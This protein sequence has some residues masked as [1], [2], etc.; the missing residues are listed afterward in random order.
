MKQRKKK[1]K[2][3]D[4]RGSH[5]SGEMEETTARRPKH[6]DVRTAI[7][8]LVALKQEVRDE[9]ER[10]KTFVGT[11]KELAKEISE[12]KQRIV[13][14]VPEKQ[15]YRIGTFPSKF[16]TKTF[17]D[18]VKSI[19]G[20]ES[21]LDEELVALLQGWL[22]GAETD[23]EEI[24]V[25][26]FEN[27]VA[28]N[29]PSTFSVSLMPIYESISREKVVQAV[30][31]VRD[32]IDSCG[33]NESR[34]ALCVAK[35]FERIREIQKKSVPVV[36]FGKHAENEGEATNTRKRKKRTT[37]FLISID[38]DDG[39]SASVMT[40]EGELPFEDIEKSVRKE[41]I[42]L[43]VLQWIMATIERRVKALF[44][45][46]VKEEEAHASLIEQFVA[47]KASEEGIDL[48]GGGSGAEEP[49]NF[50]VTEHIP[51]SSG[52][53]EGIEFDAKIV[54][55]PFAA[56]PIVP[57]TKKSVRPNVA[58][59]KKTCE[60]TGLRVFRETPR[61]RRADALVDSIWSE[62]ESYVPT[63]TKRGS[64]ELSG[65]GGGS[66]SSKRG[67]V[68]VEFRKKSHNSSSP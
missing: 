33:D 23:S 49:T 59:L 7:V 5:F 17:E 27:T 57:K 64:E 46:I 2:I 26:T 14:A 65:G 19:C 13:D 42:T 35:L 12:L 47:D 10:G 48:G 8:N 62:L 50:V 9:R 44:G 20:P 60:E 40:E 1:K 3:S 22:L 54:F 38:G 67:R 56:E 36:R 6:D 37:A 28:S 15:K 34:F 11:R 52:V 55:K 61:D 43:W 25:E 4:S 24:E 18:K 41:I 30:N 16:A 31:D 32:Q 58:W 66:A 39:E 68:A 21:R 63:T 51:V 45:D 29:W 53:R